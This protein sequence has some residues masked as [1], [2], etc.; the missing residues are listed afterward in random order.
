MDRG[1]PSPPRE[2]PTPPREGSGD[3]Q[4]RHCNKPSTTPH[5]AAQGKT[6]SRSTDFVVKKKKNF[7]SLRPSYFSVALRARRC[8]LALQVRTPCTME[9]LCTKQQ[10][11]C[12]ARGVPWP[13]RM[14]ARTATGDVEGFTRGARMRSHHRACATGLACHWLPAWIDSGRNPPGVGACGCVARAIAETAG[15]LSAALRPHW[16]AS[17][18]ATAVL[19]CVA[20]DGV[21]WGGFARSCA[22]LELCRVTPFGTLD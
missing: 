19:L 22:V 21:V 8:A 7:A 10:Q 9:L 17:C 2:P 3:Q 15:L 13:S 16:R 18:A 6:S 4:A 20:A 5:S 14:K 1:P 11:Y 12:E